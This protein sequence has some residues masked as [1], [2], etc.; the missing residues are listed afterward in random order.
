MLI[1]HKSQRL[2]LLKTVGIV[3]FLFCYVS[4]TRSD[5][6]QGMSEDEGNVEDEPE[7][8]VDEEKVEAARKAREARSEKLRKM[9]DEA[10]TLRSLHFGSA[11]AY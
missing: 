9:M 4:L 7:V 3:A 8:K 5:P 1:G 2:R 10:G 11:Q 6:M